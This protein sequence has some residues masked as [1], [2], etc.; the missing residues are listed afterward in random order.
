MVSNFSSG[1][2]TDT[3]WISEATWGTASMTSPSIEEPP[4]LPYFETT[5]ERSDHRTTMAGFHTKSC[6]EVSGGTCGAHRKGKNPSCINYHY[7]TQRR[8]AP[9][10]ATGKMLYWDF[11]CSHAGEARCPNGDSCIFAHNPEEISYHPAKYKTR[12][13]NGRGCRGL[14]I[15]CFAHGEDE[16]RKWAVDRYS[17]SSHTSGR[18]GGK[19][20]GN[21][22]TDGTGAPG[23]G[24]RANG[25]AGGAPFRHKQRFCASYPNVS[26]C[27]RGAACAFA[28]TRE[29]VCTPLLTLEEEQHIAT[30]LTDSFFM[31]SFKTLWCPIGVQHDWQSCVY[32]HNYQDAR[33]KVSIGYGPRPCP[34]WAKKDVGSSYTQRCPYGL[35]C[36]FSHG[37]KEQLYHPQYFRT[38]ICRDVRMKACP[39]EELC[40][41]FHKRAERRRPPADTTHY[42]KPLPN[43][44][45][46]EA[47]VADFTNPP[48]QDTATSGDLIEGMTDKADPKA[49]EESAEF[50]DQGDGLVTGTWAELLQMAFPGAVAEGHGD[51]LGHLL[52]NGDALPFPF[53]NP[54]A[55]GLGLPA[56]SGFDHSMLQ[57]EIFAKTMQDSF[58]HYMAMMDP[59]AGKT[60]GIGENVAFDGEV[61]P[62]T[63]AGETEDDATSSL[64]SSPMTGFGKVVRSSGSAAS[65]TPPTKLSNQVEYSAWQRDMDKPWKVQE[66]SYGP[67]VSDAF[68][69]FLVAPTKS[70]PYSIRTESI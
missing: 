2:S 58:A 32:A 21:C 66:P 23:L 39:R 63:R 38:V 11:P 35:H 51:E 19:W 59:Y 49:V 70:N 46:P 14:A 47:W 43:D 26:Q 4:P 10:D 1:G 34:Y 64:R 9:F 28:H 50:V 18:A 41:F 52:P 54:W 5:D 61:T 29:E 17:C 13:C 8:R 69:S 33:R 67:L 24:G 22:V 55:L 30:S 36:P 45:L 56:T 57:N 16:M 65:A 6:N 40:A 20:S 31:F 27:R 42:N 53:V 7:E 15:C 62:R 25:D 37:A 60:A 44:A 68:Q 48:F 3:P 12:L